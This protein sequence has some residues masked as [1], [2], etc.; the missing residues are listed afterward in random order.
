MINDQQLGTGVNALGVLV[1][2]AIVGYHYVQGL[3]ETL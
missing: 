3:K 2:L 1:F